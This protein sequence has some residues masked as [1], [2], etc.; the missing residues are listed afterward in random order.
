[1]LE[2]LRGEEETGKSL[3]D[4]KGRRFDIKLFFLSFFLSFF[5]LSFGRCTYDERLD[6]LDIPSTFPRMI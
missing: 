1:M 5:L 6:C 2:T 4:S 3:G